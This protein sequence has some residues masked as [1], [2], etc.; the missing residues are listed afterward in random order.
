MLPLPII[1]WADKLQVN[2]F[3]DR[4]IR[5]VCMEVVVSH[6]GPDDLIF[7]PEGVDVQD[8][9]RE[10]LVPALLQLERGECLFVPHLILAGVTI[11]RKRYRGGLFLAVGDHM[12]FVE[13]V[14]L[15]GASLFYCSD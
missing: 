9:W 1:I 6:S 5:A 15:K 7:L 14:G 4:S 13:L 12:E 11:G 10:V 8:M 2:P 3:R